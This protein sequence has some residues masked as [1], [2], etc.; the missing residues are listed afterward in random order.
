MPLR[1]FSVFPPLTH[2]STLRRNFRL[3][4]RL[5]LSFSNGGK[6]FTVDVTAVTAAREELRLFGLERRDFFFPFAAALRARIALNRARPGDSLR[7]SF[8]IHT[9]C[10]TLFTRTAQAETRRRRAACR[11]REHPGATATRDH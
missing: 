1:C 6:A 11:E 5:A 3:A 10:P 7:L 2:R 9:K 4:F 8:F